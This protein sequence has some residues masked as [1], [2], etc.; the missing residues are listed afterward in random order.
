M[1]SFLANPQESLDE[2]NAES[3][4]IC[5]LRSSLDALWVRMKPVGTLHGTTGVVPRATQ[6]GK[7]QLDCNIRLVISYGNANLEFA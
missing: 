4:R 6:R 2:L 7:S 5:E 1:R 3:T